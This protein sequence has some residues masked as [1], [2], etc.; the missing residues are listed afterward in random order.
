M[1]LVGRV[2]VNSLIMEIHEGNT[3]KNNQL[4]NF[5]KYDRFTQ[6]EEF[7]SEI[8]N[9]TAY[10]YTDS[11]TI[12]LGADTSLNLDGLIPPTINTLGGKVTNKT[13]F[14]NALFNDSSFG[15]STKP[16]TSFSLDL[17]LS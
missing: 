10:E 1:V 2:G 7:V 17:N 5:G 8:T 3:L 14:L 12:A 9:Q 16:L 11:G 15:V 4:E 13:W 6:R